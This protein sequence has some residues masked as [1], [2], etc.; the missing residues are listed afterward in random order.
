MRADY[1]ECMRSFNALQKLG[2]LKRKIDE[3]TNF[4]YVMIEPFK[5]DKN[6]RP[7]LSEKFEEYGVITGK[8]DKNL[9]MIEQMA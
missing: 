2:V 5:V 9:E 7:I 8:L 4:W 3:K 6:S 1:Q